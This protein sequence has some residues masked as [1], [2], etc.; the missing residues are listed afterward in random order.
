MTRPT[1]FA[2]WLRYACAALLVSVSGAVVVPVHAQDVVREAPVAAPVAVTPPARVEIPTPRD[3]KNLDPTT[4]G[5][6]LIHGNYCGVGQRPGGPID[7][8]DVACMHH[9]ACTPT[10]RLPTCE[11]NARLRDEAAAVARDPRQPTELQSLASVVATAATVMLC[12]P[13]TSTASAPPPAAPP[14]SIPATSDPAEPVSVVPDAVSADTASPATDAPVPAGAA[15]M[16]IA[17]KAQSLP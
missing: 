16:P 17:P 7:A 6:T 3:P 10:G 13:F 14:S 4:N 2:L 15:P 1:H 11:C 5:L 9:D 12:K 8:L